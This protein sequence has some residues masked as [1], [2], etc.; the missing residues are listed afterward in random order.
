MTEPAPT[1]G[2]RQR[3]QKLARSLP[4]RIVA[5]LYVAYLLAGFF[6]V[7][8]LAQKLL[9][10][11]GERMLASRLAA[12]RVEFNPFTLELRVHKLTLSQPD[13]GFLAGFDRLDVNLGVSG[14]A[15]WATR[16]Q[17]IELDRPHLHLEQRPGGGTNWDA[18]A[19]KLR[20]GSG[21]PSRTIV[22]L[23]IDHI[24]ITD[25]D[26]S[27]ADADRPGE[28][29][30]VSLQPLNLALEE[31]STL[32]EDRGDYQ[33]SARM[34]DQGATLRWKGEVGLNPLVSEGDVALEGAR[35]DR[36]AGALGA[37]FRAKAAGTLAAQLHYRFAMV[38][39]PGRPDQ[40]SL[41]VSG[42]QAQVRDL[43]LALP[44]GGEPL[45]QVPEARIADASFD[46]LSRQ[47]VLGDVSLERGQVAVTLDAQGKP[48]WQA[49]I[50]A[51]SAPAAAA[52]GAASPWKVAVRAIRLAGW[53]ARWTDQGFVQP[54]GLAV[55]GLA[56]TA[57][58]DGEFGAT[59]RLALGPVDA[60]WGPVR[61]TSGAEPVAQLRHAV[62]TKASVQL[63]DN[64]IRVEGLALSGLRASVNLDREQRLDWAAILRRK[65]EA[66]A[67]TAVGRAVAAHA[68][69]DL[70]VARVSV[71][72][73]GLR[74]VDAAP[75]S[76]V[77]LDLTDGRIALAN[78]G[79][80]LGR[81][82][83]VEASFAVRQGGRFEAQG[84]VVPGQPSG[85]LRLRL[86]GLSLKPFA[87]YVNRFARL[88]L[89]A[90]TAGTRGT[91]DFAPAKAGLALRYAGGFS[92]DDLAITEEDT[93]DAF[94][95]W[96]KLSS[97]SLAVS[98]APDR[99][100]IGELTALDPVGKVI[101]FEDQT[102][103]LQRIRR[104]SAPAAPAAAPAGQA[105][106]D[107]PVAIDRLRITGGSAQFADLSLTP[108]FGTRMH[109]L[110]GVVTGLSTDPAASAQVELD[111]KV[112]DYGSVR[113]RGSIQPFRATEATDLT[114]AF[115]NLEM[116][117]LT[118]YSGKFA[119]RKIESGRLSV[120]LGYKIKDRQLAGTNKFVVH[121]LKLGERVDSPTAVKLPLDLAI[122]VLQ[123]SNGV[124]DLDLPVSGSL[125]D[126]HFSYGA[127]LWKAIVNVLTKIVTAPFRAL[128]ALLGADAE[129]MEAVGFD[130][131][132]SVLLPPEQEKLKKLAVALA[133]RPALT[134]TI[135]P[136]YDPEADRRALQE[137][138]MRRQ[139]AGV[140]GVK[141]G[142]GEDPGPVDVNNYKV[143]TWLEDRYA[144]QAGKE[145]YQKLR[146]SYQPK[147]ASAAA[148]A[149][150]SQFLTRLSRQFG[151]RE[152]GP[153][154]AFHAELLERLTRAVPVADEALVA[155]A[156]A[157]AQALREAIVK[158]GLDAARVS[159]GA[160]AP[161]AA[162]DKQVA[163]GLTL[164]AAAQAR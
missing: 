164:G 40:P 86:A 68:A 160:P 30:R 26:I 101:I 89:H 80:D 82:I 42:G 29:F 157:R 23:L 16:I 15:R 14:V 73:I 17:A 11:V 94:L 35:L 126:P 44:D 58:L 115:H 124:I 118:P 147:D 105:T 5:G 50:A 41:V 31:I 74:L 7:N 117:R 88:R 103:N 66:V 13:G 28:P 24:R 149:M 162:K 113:V 93:G 10:W 83:P 61:L 3:L 116:T 134:L 151:T 39:A 18:L 25:G 27:Y 112:D 142:A 140:A 85:Q 49:L 128:G 161:H 32:P 21:P 20:E 145:A 130:P 131:G 133:K 136:G 154:S 48:D 67:G 119:G 2:P 84:S 55:E 53:S 127:I 141:L 79:L 60:D 111:G 81:A 33:L 97:D 159:M 102:L 51:P 59:T 90:G 76:P 64:R 63:P 19:A 43:S 143:Q 155:L 95:G 69:P 34:P 65:P 121:Q 8:P 114:L 148:R 139:A 156:Q 104:T 100:H 122:A 52:A 12:E 37:W 92:V 153:P 137:A 77:T 99:L 4:V 6:L 91:L 109:G 9:P 106:A 152:S 36:L 46:L 125:D 78:V 138:A 150:D 1:P 62:L 98:L 108:Q 47:L 146:A 132:R 45:L 163:C 22:R 56:L 72:D 87:P 107:F 123:D 158:Q 144:A 75:A 71:E 120:D 38:R 57:A 96:K 54:L 110:D 70:Q 129:K 135:E